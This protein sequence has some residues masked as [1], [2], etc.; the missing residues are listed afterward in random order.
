MGNINLV[1][2]NEASWY[3][4]MRH[5]IIGAA[6]SLCMWLAIAVGLFAYNRDWIKEGPVYVKLE[7]HIRKVLIIQSKK[8]NHSH[9]DTDPLK[10]LQLNEKF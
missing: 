3:Q 2:P 7:V 1:G 6:F 10:M 5:M 8:R 4:V 9:H